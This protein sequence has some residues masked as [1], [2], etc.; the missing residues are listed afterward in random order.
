MIWVLLITFSG[1]TTPLGGFASFE[2]CAAARLEF[3][4][5]NPDTPGILQCVTVEGS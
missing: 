4:A 5:Q 3:A 2:E 1:Y